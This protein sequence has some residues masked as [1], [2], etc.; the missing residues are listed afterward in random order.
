LE[1]Q[2]IGRNPGDWFELHLEAI[3]KAAGFQTK[4]DILFN[5]SVRHEIDIFAESKFASIAIECKDWAYIN[6]S[7]LKK[8]LDAF[9]TKVGDIDATTGVFALNQPGEFQ[10]YRDYLTNHRLSFWDS[11][12]VEQWFNSMSRYPERSQFQKALCDSL[13]IMVRPA[14]SSSKLFGFLRKAGDAS[15]K[16]AVFAAKIADNLMEPPLPPKRRAK[17]RNNAAKKRAR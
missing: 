13:G 14:T 11:A 16:S 17:R 9:I 4:R 6:S 5:H 12:E 8:E 15:I 10:R 3:F 7:V 1:A 2:R